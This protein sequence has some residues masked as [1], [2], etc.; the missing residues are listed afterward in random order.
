[1]AEIKVLPGVNRPDL[2]RQTAVNEVLEG[3]GEAGLIHIAIVGRNAAGDI[4]V[5]SSQSDADAVIG[6]FTRGAAFLV[7]S[8][9]VYIEEPEQGAS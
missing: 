8:E 9:Q 1:M 3:A 4:I 2:D 6:L 5:F 7:G